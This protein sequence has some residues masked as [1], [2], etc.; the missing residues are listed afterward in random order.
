MKISRGFESSE[1]SSSTRSVGFLRENRKAGKPLTKLL[2]A[3]GLEPATAAP[4]FLDGGHYCTFANSALASLYMGISGSACFQ[5][6]KK[7]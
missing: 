3:V 7:S 6:M 1:L 2:A 4:G 5:M